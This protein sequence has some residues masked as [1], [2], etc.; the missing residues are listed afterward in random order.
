MSRLIARAKS[1]T[2]V[3]VCMYKVEWQ[4]EKE[5]LKKE[6]DALAQCNDNNIISG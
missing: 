1:V 5:F 3:Y 2:R 6:C 4:R